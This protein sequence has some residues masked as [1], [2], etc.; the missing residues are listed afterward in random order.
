MC[1]VSNVRREN[2]GGDSEWV[3]VRMKS[4]DGLVG[5]RDGK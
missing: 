2:A 4:Q 3:S 1:V 5:V